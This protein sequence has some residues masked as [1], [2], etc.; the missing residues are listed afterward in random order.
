M[1]LCWKP[2]RLR[3]DNI[4][5]NGWQS[6]GNLD[7]IGNVALQPLVFGGLHFLGRSEPHILLVGGDGYPSGVPRHICDLAQ[8][9]QGIAKVS[10]LSEPD[11]GGYT[12]LRDVGARHVTRP[13][14]ASRMR[15]RALSSGRAGLLS[16]LQAEHYD[17]VWFHARLPVLLGRHL[18][19]SG[20]WQPSET[21]V[22]ISY[23]GLPLGPGH[24]PLTG[25]TS[26]QVERYL[27]Q[28]CPPLELVC[29][30]AVQA[31]TLAQ[32]VGAHISRH[33]MHLLGNTSRLGPLPETVPHGAGRH[34]VMT[35]R[36][37]WQKNYDRALRLM[38]H[39]PDDI[40]LTLCGRGTD[41]PAFA[42]RITQLAGP[43]A[44][45]VKVAGPVTDVRPFL[46]SADGYLLTSRYE[47][48]PIGALEASEAGLPLILAP[49]AGAEEL[50]AE[51]PLGLCLPD[52][53][54]AAAA[55]IDALLHRYR[56]ARETLG[57]TIHAHW[58]ARYAPEAFDRAARALVEG[59]LGRE[60]RIR[61]RG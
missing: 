35:G 19:A 56:E 36:A 20:A 18:L 43:V 10:V 21:Q 2:S 29:L 12:P 44:Q 33:R 25:M 40:Y 34:L 48:M 49:F 3:G 61:K 37:G 60:G 8:A 6:S 54:K 52:A 14:L 1:E 31:R 57:P 59:W 17:L 7:F 28:R 55:A 58:A 23:H 26:R 15:P 53:P 9:L 42:R 22:A 47:G 5:Q 50:L 4:C 51:H 24:R 16:V 39:L 32:A 27:L 38:R 46:A 11:R 41:T 45:R 30:N 13:G